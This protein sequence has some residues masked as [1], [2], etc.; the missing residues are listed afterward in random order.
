[1]VADNAPAGD[2][3]DDAAEG[4]C[5]SAGDSVRVNE[6]VD[7]MVTA[8]DVEQDRAGASHESKAHNQTEV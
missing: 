3:Q 6:A 1:V 4:E 5:S 7:T 2:E 8:E